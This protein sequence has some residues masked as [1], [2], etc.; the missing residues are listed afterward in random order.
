[1]FSIYDEKAKAF[2]P[3]WFLPEQGQAIRTFG[4]HVNSD[5][6][7]GKHPGDYTLFYLGSFNDSTAKIA[8][9]TPEALGNGVEFI[10]DHSVKSVISEIEEV[11]LPSLVKEQAS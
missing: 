8:L 6:N 3:P 11:E 7:I 2:F 5:D 10:I 9:V 1:M 4:D